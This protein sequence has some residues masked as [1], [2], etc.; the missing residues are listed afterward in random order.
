M[1]K[2]L[3]PLLCSFSTQLNTSK[4]KIL[5]RLLA[6]RD[7]CFQTVT[8]RWIRPWSQLPLSVFGIVV[9][10]CSFAFNVKLSLFAFLRNVSP[11]AEKF[12]TLQNK[13]SPHRGKSETVKMLQQAFNVKWKL[14]NNDF[15][16]QS[17]K[18]LAF[19]FPVVRKNNPIVTS[20]SQHEH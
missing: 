3:L 13:I 18:R 15:H 20:T 14:G 9:P 17:L 16:V 5:K 1:F 6:F 12:R 11:S 19:L 8:P 2:S 10:A 4:L 7:V